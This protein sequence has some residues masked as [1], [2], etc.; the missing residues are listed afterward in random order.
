MK[1]WKMKKSSDFDHEIMN[2]VE[3]NVGTPA[4]LD[5]TPGCPKS[6]WKTKKSLEKPGKFSSMVP[7]HEEGKGVA[8]F[9]L[10]S[11]HVHIMWSINFQG[12][13][14]MGSIWNRVGM[15]PADINQG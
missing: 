8:F 1:L 4:I 15:V 7:S 10:S 13:I 14:W 12:S 9:T 5:R 2:L 3:K 6:K 11:L